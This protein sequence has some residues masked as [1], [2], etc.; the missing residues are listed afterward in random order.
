MA[1][2]LVFMIGQAGASFQVQKTRT[3]VCTALGLAYNEL[4]VNALHN[5]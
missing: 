1:L 4:I 5:Y 3:G 2:T